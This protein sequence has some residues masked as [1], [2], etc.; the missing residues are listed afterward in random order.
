ES[1]PNG[2]VDPG[3]TVTVSL[4]LQNIGVLN[5]TN[6]VATLQAGGGVNAP[7]GPQTYGALTA[8]GSAVSRPFTFTANGICGGTLTA[9]LQL[10]DGPVNLGA[11][12]FTLPL[13][14]FI[15]TNTFTENFD[16]IT[17]PNLPA[18]WS[19]TTTGA[20][21]AWS[22]SAAAADT[23]P[24]AAYSTDASSVGVNELVSPPLSIMSAAAQL[25]FRNNYDLEASM[26]FPS[27]AYDGGVLEIQIGSGPFMDILAAG[28]SFASGGYTRTISSQ[29]GNP[30]AGRQAWS[31]NSGG[32]ITTVVNL[33]PAAAGQSIML[34]WRCGT[35]QSTG[36]GGWY[37]DTVS[38]TDG[39]YACCRTL[40][41]PLITGVSV[42][43]SNVSISVYS[44]GGLNYTLEYKNALTDAGW[45][46]LQPAVT[47]TG[48]TILLPDTNATPT[49]RFYRVRAE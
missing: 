10:K 14:Q 17:V 11:V 49:S 23:A 42:S 19:T 5:T 29:H 36:A 35:D 39:A 45:V 21:A 47:G 25:T 2:A 22:T 26:A 44:V 7:G 38:V 18:N 3:E 30:L 40:V 34:K 1:C 4:A 20:Q 48:G 46:S 27:R 24:N 28:G 8:G 37:I 43:G 41:P 9:T 15:A 13:G 12:S 31:G 16:G 6:L 32:F 33:P